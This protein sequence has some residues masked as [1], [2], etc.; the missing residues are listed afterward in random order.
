[1]ELAVGYYG[2]ELSSLESLTIRTK[3]TASARD[4]RAFRPLEKETAAKNLQIM[5]D[6]YELDLKAV[7]VIKQY[8]KDEKRRAPVG[9][10]D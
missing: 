9:G 10:N 2:E 8:E 5:I 4:Q 1:M 7:D 3:Q 6:E